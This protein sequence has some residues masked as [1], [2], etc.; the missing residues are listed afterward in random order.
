MKYYTKAKAVCTLLFMSFSSLQAQYISPYNSNGSIKSV[1]QRKYDEYKS[2]QNTHP[3]K[4]Q[5]KKASVVEPLK[6]SP[7]AENQEKT[8]RPMINFKGHSY[9]MIEPFYEGLAVVRTNSK[10]GYIDKSGKLII[11]MD[12]DYAVKFVN[13]LGRVNRD[14]KYGFINKKGVF[15]IPLI[16][17]DSGFSFMEDC[18]KMRLEGKWGFLDSKGNT[19]VPCIYEEVRFFKDGLANVKLNGKWVF[20][21]KTGKLVDTIKE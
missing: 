14:G 17:D 16:Y 15:I 21:D 5:A 8:V 2:K 11:P 18:V 6:S 19:I 10:F 13:G 12:Y 4:P 20:V 1:E 7:S 9:E 3:P